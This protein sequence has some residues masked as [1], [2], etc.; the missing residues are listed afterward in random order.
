[1]KYDVVVIGAG[2]AGS[3]A[4]KVLAERGVKVLLLDKQVFP[5]EKPCGGGL[6][7]RALERFPYLRTLDV[8]ESYSYGGSVYYS[9]LEYKAD[10][11]R[12]NP[13][14]AMVLR[15]T[16][17]DGLV[18]CA[19]EKGATFWGG[20]TVVDVKPSEERIVVL[21]DDG[22]SLEAELVIGADGV[23]SRVAQQMGLSGAHRAVSLC[24]FQ[25]YPVTKEVLDTFFSEKRLCRIFVQFQD[26]IGYGWVF[27]KKDSVNIGIDELRI[28]GERYK[29]I[30][31]LREA[32]TQFFSLLK[33]NGM[34]PPGLEMGR[35][36]GAPIPIMPLE[37]T[38]GDRV[39]LCG[40]A[41]GFVNPLTG[42]GLYYAMASGELAAGVAVEALAARDMSAGFLRRYQ[43][44]WTDEFGVDLR[45]FLRVYHRW[46]RF[47]KYAYRVV[48]SDPVLCEMI[49]DVGVGQTSLRA[50]RRK[51]L[52]RFL[53]AVV[54][55]V[56]K[57][58]K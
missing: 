35:I 50:V 36:R 23:W 7:I 9:L 39:L 18:R 12:D 5:R 53:F 8:I 30:R 55:Y 49:L 22:T 46:E 25:E 6:P 42:E 10:L 52:L 16:F 45:L 4:A 38:F 14:L 41:A 47:V 56:V 24:V 13:I 26:I 58:K 2:P 1:M 27:P 28:E 43:D 11:Q 40:D 51:A 19:I 21:L 17:D 31:N 29:G 20:E 34:I 48:A 3:T 37:K 44:R 54:N 32:Y 33:E 15:K 57:R